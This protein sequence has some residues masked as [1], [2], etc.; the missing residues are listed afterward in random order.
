MGGNANLKSR[1]SMKGGPAERTESNEG[2]HELY[3][4]SISLCYEP[5][6]TLSIKVGDIKRT[7]A[8]THEEIKRQIAQAMTGVASRVEDM[9]TASGTKD[10]IAQHWIEQL[11]SKA[12]ETKS[13]HPGRSEAELVTEVN[14]WYKDQPGDKINPLLLL[15]GDTLLLF[16]QI[17]IF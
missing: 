8:S 16:V 5:C 1:K 12:R 15:D 13:K 11:I 2:Y 7:A 10:K 6:L 3:T 9:Q 14:D 4:V 17:Y